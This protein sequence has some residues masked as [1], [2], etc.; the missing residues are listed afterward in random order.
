[1]SFEYEEYTSIVPDTSIIIQGNLLEILEKENINYQEIIIT[2]A[3]IAELEHQANKD[4]NKGYQGLENLKKLQQLAKEEIINI[5]IEGKRPTVYE[6]KNAR[7]GEIDN[8]IRETAKNENAILI[9]SDKIQAQ[10]AKAQGI[11]TIYVKQE[12]TEQ[13]LKILKFFT[14]NTMS[15]HLKENVEPY[16]KKGLPGD[17][18]L[19]KISNKKTT[20][21][22]INEYIRDILEKTNNDKRTYLEADLEGAKVIQSKNLR[23]NINKPPFSEAIEITAVRPVAEVSLKDYNLKQDILDKISKGDH[24]ILISGSPGAGKSTF[25]QA[26]A[27][28]FSK[29]LNKIVKTMESPRDLQVPKEITQYSPLE[30]E[31]EKTADILLLVRPDITIYDEVRKTRDFEIFADMRLAGVG[32]VGVVH[33]TKPIDAIQR[34]ANRVE[35]GII[36]S[37]VDTTIFIDQGEIKN[38]Y[39]THMTVKVPTGMKEQDLAR[40]VIEVR[41]YT[42]GDLMNEIYTYGEQTIV[43]D[44]NQVQQNTENTKTPIEEIAEKQIK[45]EL[46]KYLPGVKIQVETISPDRVKVSIPKKYRPKIIGRGGKKIDEIEKHIG[47]HI[48]LDSK[49]EN[50]PQII[51][52]KPQITKKGLNIYFPKET[53]GESFDIIAN[54]N[55]LFTVTVGKGGIIKLRHDLDLTDQLI[56]YINQNKT[57]YAEKR[58]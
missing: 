19:E 12:Y 2:E 26:L 35:L 17:I 15:I 4:E 7:K 52:V 54:N 20:T 11:Q 55:F 37:I 41:D 13:K 48:T 43:M 25:A 31:M 46:K 40:P 5:Q 18:K 56:Q 34:I 30:G 50:T 1:M 14:K 10:T 38:I 58:N 22:E 24:G 44:V 45:R 32:M 29:N 9:T 49:E 8:L 36:P 42:T 33:A 3:S 23:I 16:A 28:Y 21:D 57:I 27:T 51:E 39:Q 47:I 6:I 53:V